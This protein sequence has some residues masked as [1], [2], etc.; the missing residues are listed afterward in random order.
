LHLVGKDIIRFHAVYWPA[1]LMA[2]MVPLPKQV[3]AHGW[4][5]MDAA[6]MSKSKGNVVTPRPIV[7]VLGMD[8]LRYFLLREVAFG[9]D[10][11]FS[12]DALVTRYNAD[13]ANGLGNLASRCA[14]LIEKG[15][16][17]KIPKPDKLKT[18]DEALAKEAEA[19][20]AEVLEGYEN[21][22]FSRTLEQI[23]SLIAAADKY[24]TSEQP[25]ALGNSEEDQQRRAT[26]LWTTSELLRVVTMLAHPVL[27][28][29]T[30]RVWALLGQSG[31]VSTQSLDELHWGQLAPGTALGKSQTLFPRIEKAEAIERI[32]AMEN[33]AQKQPAPAAASTPASAPAGGGAAAA[34]VPAAAEKIAIEDFA[35]VEMRVGEIKTAE[36]IVGA[37]KLLKLT[38][39]I[40]TEI[41]QIC[42]GIAQ[43]YEPENLI[44]RKVAVV[45]NLAPRK[46]R[47]VESNGMIIA[48]AVGPEGR[49]V[50]AGF[51]EDVEVGARLK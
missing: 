6:K 1:F 42:A 9:Q 8:A 37:D 11:N 30:R 50:L 38:V 40:G 28:D 7:G 3:W 51:L 19:A 44:G 33:E 36:R 13:L 34:A 17:G 25:W 23:W 21:L 20:I 46:L 27:P 4:F 29:S 31:S 49:P 10:G 5:L 41:R 45:V 14:A 47:G 39:D 16:G 32:E 12:Y 26:I 35:K 24:L 18:Q 2:A 15:F 22:S 43:H 48:A